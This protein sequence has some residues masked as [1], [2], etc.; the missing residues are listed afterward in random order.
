MFTYHT[1][2]RDLSIKDSDIKATMAIVHGYG[3]NSDIF[4]ESAI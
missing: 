3:E 1:N 4:L 2:I